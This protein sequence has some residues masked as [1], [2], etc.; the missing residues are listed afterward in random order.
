MAVLKR[1]GKTMLLIG[2]I[3]IG[4]LMVMYYLLDIVKPITKGDIITTRQLA[5]QQSVANNTNELLLVIRQLEEANRNL[6]SKLE[7]QTKSTRAIQRRYDR[8]V[9][10]LETMQAT[11]PG[12]I[13]GGE[14][15]KVTLD[16]LR[17]L[18][19]RLS[20]E[21]EVIPYSLFNNNYLYT[22]ESSMINNPEIKPLEDKRREMDE[23]INS[24]LDQLNRHKTIT[25]VYTAKDFLFGNYRQDR[26]FGTQYE[27]YFRTNRLD[28][29]NDHVTLFRPFAPIQPVVME[30]LDKMNE[31]VNIIM[32]LQGRLAQF[33]IYLDMY[34]KLTK[35]D[36]KLFLTVVY[37][38]DNNTIAAKSMLQEAAKKAKNTN[39]L[40][41]EKDGNFSRG[42]GL[43]TGANAWQLNKEGDNVLLFFCDVDIH[44]NMKFL[45]RCRLNS[46]PGSKV[47]YPVVFSMYNPQLVY[48]NEEE[49]PPLKDRFVIRK[50]NGFWRTF[51]YG[52]TCIYKS[53]FLLGREIDTTIR[54][55]GLEDVKLYRKLIAGSLEVMRSPDRDIYHIWHE[56]ECNDN[57]PPA[58]YNM[59]VGSR[60][61]TDGTVKQLGTIAY[62]R[63]RKKH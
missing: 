52:M 62:G 17:S 47:Y 59:C 36:S 33:Q 40:F 26:T 24:A 60:A 38:K 20:S 54:G 34:F 28:I 9:D 1:N 27:L 25:K 19:T 49:V 43:L 46:G 31:W 12:E 48:M 11:K 30:T 50:D 42:E 13:D 2:L 58:Q 63:S 37:F 5:K 21:Y 53:D 35:Q 51:G 29:A 14:A 55:W 23:V 3:S 45:Q 8:L 56:K 15:Q 16:E 22:V 6:Q 57:L 4:M 18:N 10:K 41:I 32:P 61:M 39:W 7:L 44:F